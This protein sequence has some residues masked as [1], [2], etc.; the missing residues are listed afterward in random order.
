MKTISSPTAKYAVGVDI[1]GTDEFTLYDCPL[2]QGKAGVMKIAASPEYNGNL[3]REAYILQTLRNEALEIENRY[4]AE[5]GERES[6]GYQLM[7]PR[8]VESFVLPEEEGGLHVL[9]LAV[10]EIVDDIR[11]LV[12]LERLHLH[13]HV[14]IDPKTS[15][16]ILGKLLKLLD[17]AHGFGVNVVVN[18]ENIVINPDKHI[19]LIFDWSG[20]TVRNHALSPGEDL[21]AEISAAAREVVL[22]LGGDPETCELPPDKQLEGDWYQN[23]LQEISS[24]EIQSAEDAHGRFYDA[25]RSVWPKKFHPFT[26]HSLEETEENPEEGVEEETTTELEE[27][28]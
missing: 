11:K 20:S 10:D 8:L 28:E 2:P 26:T 15:V 1:G 23:L 25:V 24:G 14:R 12:P 17:F 13:E 4:K 3:D 18:G 27:R 7:L 5:K 6:L 22:A 9:I 21:A 16:W 19:V